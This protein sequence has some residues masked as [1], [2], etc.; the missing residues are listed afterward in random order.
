MFL[1]A[2]MNRSQEM[3]T[4]RFLAFATA[5]ALALL[6]VVE[7]LRIT[8]NAPQHPSR[9]AAASERRGARDG[10]RINPVAMPQRHRMRVT[11]PHRCKRS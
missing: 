7:L 4:V 10:G 8:T 5:A 11:V 2:F 1:P 9:A 3:D 6:M